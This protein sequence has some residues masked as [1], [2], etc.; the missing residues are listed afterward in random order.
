MPVAR[1]DSAH[2]D[3]PSTHSLASGCRS[4][5]AVV[6]GHATSRDASSSCADKRSACVLVARSPYA[7]VRES[8]GARDPVLMIH[9]ACSGLSA[10]RGFCVGYSWRGR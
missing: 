9:A 2:V 8:C 10:Y 5:G 1:H 3:V 6:V 4:S 7:S